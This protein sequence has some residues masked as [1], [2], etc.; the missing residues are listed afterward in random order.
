MTAPTATAPFSILAPAYRPADLILTNELG[1]HLAGP[2]PA[3]IRRHLEAL[4]TSFNTFACLEAPGN[5]YVQVLRGTTGHHLECRITRGAHYSHFRAHFHGASRRRKSLRKT[6]GFI[7]DGLACD[8]L[9]LEEVID[10]F[11]AFRRRQ[12][13]PPTLAWRQ[14]EL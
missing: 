12:D 3:E 6:D 9:P 11:L 14:L 4:E 1:L 2:P 8:I 5:T 10:A 7:S 13:L